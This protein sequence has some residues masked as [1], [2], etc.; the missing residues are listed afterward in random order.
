MSDRVEK[1]V[2]LTTFVKNNVRDFTVTNIRDSG[3]WIDDQNGVE[4]ATSFLTCMCED[5]DCNRS[6]AMDRYGAIA[7]DKHKYLV[8]R[9]FCSW[10]A[11]PR[12]MIV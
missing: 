6:V 10:A 11:W 5:Y 9:H 7:I 3:S 2:D 12:L 4:T 1:F 8:G